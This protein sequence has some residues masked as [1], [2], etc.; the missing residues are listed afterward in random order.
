VDCYFHCKARCLTTVLTVPVA[1]YHWIAG[2]D[3]KK[4]WGLGTRTQDI[5]NEEP[6]ARTIS[7]KRLYIFSTNFC[8]VEANQLRNVCSA[9][10]EMCN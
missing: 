5:S 7:V 8:D 2:K 10:K 6:D 9:P 3:S 1:L 4:T